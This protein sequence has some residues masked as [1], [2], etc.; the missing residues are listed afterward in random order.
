MP[1]KASKIEEEALRLP[2]HKKAILVKR[3]IQSLD[4]KEDPE[5]EELWIK[6]AE[7]R[8]QEY[9]KGKIKARPAEAVLKEAYSK[10]K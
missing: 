10:L 5:A 7:R 4:E 8:Y 1:S 3:L 6:E 9:K 2:F